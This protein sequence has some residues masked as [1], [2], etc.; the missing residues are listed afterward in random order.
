MG[1]VESTEKLVSFREYARQRG[2]SLQAVQRAIQ[3]KR[4]SVIL[5]EDGIPKINPVTADIEWEKNTQK[6]YR[7]HTLARKIQKEISDARLEKD[8]AL[9]NI[10]TSE[11]MSYSDSRTVREAYSARLMKLEYEVKTGKLVS[12]EDVKREYFQILR[13]TRDSIL[14]IP[15]R[16]SSILAA[17][18]DAARIHQL[19][20]QELHQA[21]EELSREPIPQES[22]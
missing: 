13:V 5:D 17:E 22:S 18:N 15:D 19:I 11:P 9:E 14:N 6:E 8:R 7:P 20:T 16:I 2:V 10:A 3:S 12:A 21:L 1:V 4:I